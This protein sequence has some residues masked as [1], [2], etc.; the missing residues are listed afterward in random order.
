[1]I[2][3]DTL[4][5]P[6][7]ILEKEDFDQPYVILPNDFK[8]FDD[9]YELKH[10]IRDLKLVPIKSDDIHKK[11]HSVNKED[12]L[13][14]IDFGKSNVILRENEFPYLLPKDISQ[15]IIWIK[16]NTA[17]EEVLKFI[18]DKISKIDKVILF[19][20]PL[21]IK[22]KLIKGSFPHIRHIH[23]WFKK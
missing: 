12:L 23:L 18:I 8:S 19:E 17:Q 11:Y 22:I 15:N 14:S 9:L 3:I 6:K 16:E 20:R 21:N 2:D 1:M 13:N 7:C 10:L 4:L 5:T